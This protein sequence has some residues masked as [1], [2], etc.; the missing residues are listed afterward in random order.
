[1]S[2][3]RDEQ[4]IR[5]LVAT[6]M[7]A[8]KM[9]DNDTVLSL[10][11]D[12]AVFLVPGHAMRKSDFAAAARSQAAE[13]APQ[14]DASSEIE[15]IEVLGDWAYMRTSLTVSV[16]PPG[17]GKPVVRTGHTLTILRKEAGRWLLARDANLLAPVS[18]ES[19]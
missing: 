15:E 11:T 13:G 16:T 12:D 2:V 19:G 1:M 7:S 5:E 14:F 8:T 10:M 3:E 6:W 9:G 4:Q 18:T 17:G